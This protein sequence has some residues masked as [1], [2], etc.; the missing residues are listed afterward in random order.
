VTS[1]LQTKGC[2]GMLIRSEKIN[3][4]VRYVVKSG[5]VSKE[6]KT[7]RAR[8]QDSSKTSRRLL[9]VDH[10]PKH[11]LTVDELKN[12][13]QKGRVKCFRFIWSS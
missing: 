5:G 2:W 7:E 10:R 8:P 9:T 11:D 1:V 3:Q 13:K 12:G 4:T 6:E